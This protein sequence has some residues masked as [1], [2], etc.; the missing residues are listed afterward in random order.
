MTKFHNQISQ[1]QGN[2]ASMGILLNSV[3]NQ[4]IDQIEELSSRKGVLG[5]TEISIPQK[6]HN[7]FSKTLIHRVQDQAYF[8]LISTMIK[9]NFSNIATKLTSVDNPTNNMTNFIFNQT[10]HNLQKTIKK[11]SIIE[12]ILAFVIG[13]FTFVS[14]REFFGF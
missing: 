11:N 7:M 1:V 12:I 10:S 3:K 6:E 8:E 9:N 14:I 2:Y 4:V 5:T 13:T